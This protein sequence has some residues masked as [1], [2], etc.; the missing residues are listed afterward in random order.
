[1]VILSNPVMGAL[2]EKRWQRWK[3]SIPQT[4]FQSKTRRP[5]IDPT[6]I[7]PF[8]GEKNVTIPMIDAIVM[9]AAMS[10]IV[11]K[12]CAISLQYTG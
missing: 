5:A 10:N 9:L 1:M 12:S 7:V 3:D 8:F 4:W 11:C 2:H 6:S